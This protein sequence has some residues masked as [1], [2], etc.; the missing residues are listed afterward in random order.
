[1]DG[2]SVEQVGRSEESKA[3]F[4]EK[5]RA[6]LESRQYRP[7]AVRRVYIPKPDGR[8]RPLGIPT[9][10][11]RV[12]Q[13][14]VMMILEP[15]FEADFLECSHGFRPGRGAHDAL[16]AIK[17][18]LE[19]GRTEV[20]DADLKGYFDTIPHA[21][22][23]RCVRMRVVDD[24]VLALIR[25]WLR[26]P[27]KE[28]RKDGSEGPPKRGKEGTPQGGVISPL[29]ANIY[30]H[31]FDKAFHRKDG[32]AQFAKARLVRYADDLV[33]M[34]RYMGSRIVGWCEEKLENW[35]GLKINREKTR[36]VK[37]AQEGQTVDFLGYSH[38]Q[39][40]DLCGRERKWWRQYPSKKAMRKQSEWLRQN[41]TT[42]YNGEPLREM[43]E[44][45]NTHYRGWKGYYNQG[46]PRREYRWLNWQIVQ[47]LAGVLKRRSQRGYKLPEES[48]LYEHLQNLGLEVL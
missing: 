33:V 40:R 22:L 8:Q 26:A 18:N 11:D 1:V 39:E 13:T 12:V 35:L 31:W 30:L 36:V 29:L 17:E 44:R 42:R 38:R 19:A 10:K 20:Y 32:P 48:S 16:K 15:I 28:A 23:M 37:A 45:V 25:A 43:I 5:T 41:I 46:H 2:V 24:S 4:I 34:A 3:A 9:I 27:V 6:E 7:E 14:A 47:R 21:K